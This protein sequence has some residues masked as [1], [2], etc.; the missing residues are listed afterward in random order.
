MTAGAPGT[1]HELADL[2]ARHRAL[3]LLLAETAGRWIVESPEADAKPS[4]AAAAS[5]HAWHAELWAERF[6]A[7]LGADLDLDLATTTARAELDVLAAD[8]DAA[9]STTERLARYR[10]VVDRTADALSDIRVALDERLDAPTARLL[11]LV[12]TDL[13]RC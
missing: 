11:D 6:P 10:E 5:R 3:A 9:T 12:V 7:V 4:W 13:R 2:T 1:I 8:L